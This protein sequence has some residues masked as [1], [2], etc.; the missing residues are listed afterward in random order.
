[1]KPKPATPGSPMKSA[2]T[3]TPITSSA[4][5]SS[6]TSNTTGFIR[7][8]WIWRRAFPDLV[9]AESPSQRVGGAPAEGFAR[10]KHLQPM[11]SLEKVEA[12][13]HPTKDEEPDRDKRNRLQDENT[14]AGVAGV[15][16]HHPQATWPRPRRIRHGAE[17]GRRFDQRALPPRQ[18]RARRHARRRRV[19][20]RHHRQSPHRAGDSAG[21]ER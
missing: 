6:P 17:G 19:W 3:I 18:A 5:P 4:S 2:G 1:M 7:S 13:E 15:R 8:C 20:R 10:V 21:V 14:L 16:R 9:T 12:A 11:L